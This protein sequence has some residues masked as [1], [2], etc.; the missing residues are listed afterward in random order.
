[1]PV[2]NGV[3]YGGGRRDERGDDASAYG[4]VRVVLATK[5]ID[6][7][8][9]LLFR[10]PCTNLV[11]VLLPCRDV[12][13]VG[14]QHRL[15]IAF[16]SRDGIVVAVE[17]DVG[18]WRRVRCKRAAAVLERFAQTGAWVEV[19]DETGLLF[20]WPKEGT[21]GV[22]ARERRNGGGEDVPRLQDEAL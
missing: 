11:L 18:P 2:G 13:T 16:L 6:R 4:A 21:L 17:R 20:G 19:G 10:R 8:R 14:M 5:V 9:G 22:R 12:H 3:V 7:L 15:D 1:M